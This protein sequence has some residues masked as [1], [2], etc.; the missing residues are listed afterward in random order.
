MWMD[1]PVQLRLSLD[2]STALPPVNA[3]HLENL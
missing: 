2:A 1:L 3:Y